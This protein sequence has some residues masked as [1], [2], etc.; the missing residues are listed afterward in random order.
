MAELN[1]LGISD[2]KNTR[3]RFEQWVKN[4]QCEANALSAVLNVKMSDVATSLGYTPEYGQSPFAITRGLQFEGWLFK[5]QA[6]VLRESLVKSKLLNE[7]ETGF[8]DFRLTMN[9]GSKLKSIEEAIDRTTKLLIELSNGKSES[10]PNILAGMA[11][12][13]PKGVMLPE[14][15]LIIDASLVQ[16]REAE[17][18]IKVGEIKVFPDRG[19]H[20][21]PMEISTARAQAGVYQHALS[22]AVEKLE[23]NRLRIDTQGFLVF[24]WPGSNSPVVRPN[25]DLTFQAM[26][27]EQGFDQLDK[28]AE[29]LL[30]TKSQ[31]SIDNLTW[32]THSQTEYRESCWGFCDLAARCQ[33]LA[34]QEDRAIV[35]GRDAARLLGTITVQRAIQLMEGATAESDFEN[36][37]QLQLVN[38]NWDAGTK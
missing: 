21:D 31:D 15:T 34:I 8:A 19:G 38:A 13:I 28:I 11:V 4:P 17:V 9:G 18:V 14:A 25:E 1:E 16:R 30:R 3:A 10:I 7:S 27:A 5:D 12:R 33:D 22:L 20:T 36:S 32:V 6:K 35:L 2:K 29:N 37:L 24:T 23:L 26:R